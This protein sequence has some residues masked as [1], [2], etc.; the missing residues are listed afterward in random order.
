MT[1][2]GAEPFISGVPLSTICPFR[3]LTWTIR[4]PYGGFEAKC[5]I[6]VP[7]NF[8]HHA[9]VTDADT[10]IKWG[11][12]TMFLGDLAE[13]DWAAGELYFRGRIRQGE[14]Y[15]AWE[16]TGSTT[17]VPAV[18]LETAIDLAVAGGPV[19]VSVANIT[20]AN[21]IPAR[22]A[23]QWKRTT[24]LFTTNLWATPPEEPA[25]LFPDMLDLAS[26]RGAGVPYMGPSGRLEFRTPKINPFSSG[27]TVPDWQIHPGTVELSEAGG[28]S[29]LTRV[30]VLFLDSTAAGAEKV[31]ISEDTR[32]R[33]YREDYYD[34][35][36]LDGITPAEAK[37]IA[38][39]ILAE[40][41]RPVYVSDI[42]LTPFTATTYHGAP[43][44]PL[45]PRGGDVI[46]VNGATHPRLPGSFI[47]V[48]AGEVV[49]S[50]AET[51]R[52]TAVAKPENK[53]AR[54]EDEI[55]EATIVGLRKALAA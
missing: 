20:S 4:W 37:T 10:E 8:R 41:L 26:Q 25:W 46:R 50:A 45:L 1:V 2:Y 51:D 15:K 38:D 22:T 42:D 52:P 33:P 39:A 11:G 40:H 48:T 55:A 44:N 28:D 30:Y 47:D 18:N 24:P 54:S 43:C 32:F 16:V 21:G 7:V 19:D 27:T 53:P 6:D 3:D 36:N 34:A 35:R 17:L 12:G 14:K 29:R 13:P 9:L 49:V 23:L 31:T 5:K